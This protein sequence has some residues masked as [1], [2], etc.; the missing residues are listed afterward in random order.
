[1][2]LIGACACFASAAN[3][4][5]GHGHHHHGHRGPRGPQ[6]EQGP[7]GAPGQTAAAP[8]LRVRYIT[9]TAVNIGPN[10][11]N[12]AY[13]Q[14][15]GGTS[16]T[17]GG[18][19]GSGGVNT[20]QIFASYPSGDADGDGVPDDT[21]LTLSFNSSGTSKTLTAFAVC[22]E[23]AQTRFA[24]PAA[25]MRARRPG[26]HRGPR[27]PRGPAG[28]QGPAGTNGVQVPL[29]LTYFRANQA[30]IGANSIGT[31]TA[32][33][34]AGAKVTG[35]GVYMGSSAPPQQARLNAMFPGDTNGS[36]ADDQARIEVR[37]LTASPFSATAYA[38]CLDGTSTS[39]ILPAPP[40]S[41]RGRHHHRGPRGP[42]GPQG[43]QGPPGAP[44]GSTPI[45]LVYVDGPSTAQT[46]V[47]QSRVVARC[48]ADSAVIGGGVVNTGL[49]EA[50]NGSYPS[51]ESGD[52]VP[53]AWAAYVD[54]TVAGTSI[55]HAVAICAPG[56]TAQV[57]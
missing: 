45:P 5:P 24:T 52:G 46:T 56:A 17:A 26:G 14:C 21:W 44:G 15:P 42:R 25:S 35:T 28:E 53:D 6:G 20:N 19:F 22:V 47:V 37:N 57:G 30:S 10:A 38:I 7:A 51:D 11:T 41:G 50:I 49:D 3:A 34:P 27:G 12:G 32:D 40:P 23:G 54:N 48:P 43:A 31:V 1:M 29:A 55:A 8:T 4:K 2:A 16:L 39:Q 18:A 36:V 33:C 9:G 13:A